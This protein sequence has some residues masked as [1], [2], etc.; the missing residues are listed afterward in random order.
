M[1]YCYNNICLKYSFGHELGE[2]NKCSST[3]YYD[4]SSNG[5]CI[6]SIDNYYLGLD[7]KCFNVEH[8]I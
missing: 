1:Y 2:D 8:C 6:S 3:K 7:F 4:E 5:I